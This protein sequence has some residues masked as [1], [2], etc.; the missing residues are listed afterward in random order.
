MSKKHSKQPERKCAP[1]ATESTRR[2]VADSAP[3][4]APRQTE[5][6][7]VLAAHAAPVLPPVATE[8]A[9]TAREAGDGA[10]AAQGGITGATA[11]PDAPSAAPSATR[12]ATKASAPRGTQRLPP[13]GTV[14]VKK[15]RHGTERA[16]CTVVDGG[17][18]FDGTVYKSISAAAMAAAK[19][20]GLN[21]KSLDGYAWFGL[22]SAPR[23]ASKRDATIALLRAFERYHERV[24]TAAKVDDAEQRIK[25][26]EA[27]RQHIAA[28]QALVGVGAA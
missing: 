23:A 11:A 16:R 13:V 4:A 27:I 14:I 8:S 26:Q 17:V 20:L 2:K 22:K 6:E 25:V 18:E 28:L 5:P 15:D 12:P 21:S 1:K 24:A 19:A 7:T 10:P 9:P 3:P